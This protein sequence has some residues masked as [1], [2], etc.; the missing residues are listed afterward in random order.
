MRRS[1]D[2]VNAGICQPDAVSTE[3]VKSLVCED[4]YH[5][6]YCRWSSSD[7]P[8][9]TLL[10]LNGMMSHSGWFR[11]LAH[12][13][14]GMQLDVIGADRRGSGLNERGRGDAPSRQ[15]LLSDLRRIMESED[16]GVPIYLVGWCW[17]ALPTINFALEAGKRL[18]GL[19]L[20]APGLFPS[21]QVRRAAERELIAWRAADAHS[22]VLRSPLTA[23]MFSDGAAVRDFIDSDR[24]AQRTFTRRF[25][26]ISTEMSLIARARLSQ[27]PQRLLLLLAEHDETIDTEATLRAVRRLPETAVTIATIPC[28]HG[29]QF[30]MPEA[31]AGQISQ[32]LPTRPESA[33]RFA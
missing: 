21:K 9:A 30:E 3:H 5:L 7:S 10:L 25:F 28:H 6:Q 32:W 19:V 22:P 27:L 11:E 20:F 13:L 2:G 31:I 14:I 4:G 8:V 15:A 1:R 26:E 16:S 12:F 33:V 23:E 17:G 24:L 18:S 29:M